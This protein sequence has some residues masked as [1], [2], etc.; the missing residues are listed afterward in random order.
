[1][2]PVILITVGVLFL[3]GEYSGRYSFGELWPVILIVIGAMKLLEASASTEGH[4]DKD[5]QP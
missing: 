1:M 3:I 2:G 5:R 4:V